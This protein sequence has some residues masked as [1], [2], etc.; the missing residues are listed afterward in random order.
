MTMQDAAGGEASGEAAISA[1]SPPREISIDEPRVRQI[2]N[3]PESIRVV[4]VTPLGYPDEAPAPRSRKPS[5][6]LVCMETYR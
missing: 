6:E 4:A 3:I 5:D 1:N 2:L